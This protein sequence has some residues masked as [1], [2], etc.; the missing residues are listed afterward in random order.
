MGTQPHTLREEADSA[1]NASDYNGSYYLDA[2]HITLDTVD[3][4]VDSHNFF[5]LDISEH[6]GRED[7]SEAIDSFVKSLE[8][9]LGKIE[10]PGIDEP[11]ELTEEVA[12]STAK[13]FLYAIRQARVTYD[14]IAERKGA[15]NFVTE[16]SVDETDKP[17]T[18]DMLFVILAAI[19]QF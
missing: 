1:I 11:V 4:F 5:T 16:V 3:S 2:D 13:N 12:H 6:I 14:L 17:Q 10:L 7:D 18:P 15:D 8:P 9:H 19:A